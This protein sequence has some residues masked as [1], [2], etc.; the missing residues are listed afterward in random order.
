M[1]LT[2]EKADVA[3]LI[4]ADRCPRQKFVC[5]LRKRAVVFQY[6]SVDRDVGNQSRV[7]PRFARVYTFCELVKFF[8]IADCKQVVGSAVFLL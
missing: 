1:T 6:I 7:Q 2:V 5:T 3:V 8:L 4:T